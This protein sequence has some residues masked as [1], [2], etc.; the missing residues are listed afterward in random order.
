MVEDFSRPLSFSWTSMLA[1]MML[2]NVWLG[3]FNLLPIPRRD[4]AR[5]AVLAY[6]V[7]TRR[8]AGLG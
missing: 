6:Q 3:L 5:L 2:L 1:L 7:L 4:G 8:R